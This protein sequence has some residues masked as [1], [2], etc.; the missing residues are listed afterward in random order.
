ML[1]PQGNRLIDSLQGDFELQD[2]KSTGGNALFYILEIIRREET[3]GVFSCTF[4]TNVN[5]ILGLR[6]AELSMRIGDEADHIGADDGDVHLGWHVVFF[7][8]D[9]N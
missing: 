8:R 4:S 6:L 3:I 5:D 9:S 2:D 1:T 7:L